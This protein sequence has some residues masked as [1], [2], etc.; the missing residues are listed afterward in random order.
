[1]YPALQV[2]ALRTVLACG[3]FEFKPQSTHD[4]KSVA[5]LYFPASHGVQDALLILLYPAGQPW[6]MHDP[7]V[8]LPAGE[9]EFAAQF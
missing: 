8:V 9:I 7:D 3:E 1:M 6:G 5:V 4:E 2:Q